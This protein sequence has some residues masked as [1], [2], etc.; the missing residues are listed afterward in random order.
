MISL[1]VVGLGGCLDGQLISGRPWRL[2]GWSVVG[3][4]GCLDGQLIS[5]R[6]WR[7]SG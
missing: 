3:L 1:S 2:S 4:G 6:P 5:G 7:L